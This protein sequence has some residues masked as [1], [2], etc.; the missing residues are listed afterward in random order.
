MMDKGYIYHDS[1]EDYYR[2]PFGAVASGNA[3]SLYLEVNDICQAFIELINFDGTTKTIP[4]KYDRHSYVDNYSVL[5]GVV[6]TNNS[7]G[8]LLYYFR[9]VRGG[10]TLYYGNNEECVG[11]VGKVYYDNPKPYQITVYKEF[12][13]PSWYKEGIIYQIFVDRFCNGNYNG[14][15]NNPKPNSFIYGNWNDEPLYI[16]DKEGRIIRWDFYGGNLSGVTNK[17]QY[18]KSLGV[19]IIY[20]NPIFESSSC[21]KYD[22]G[23]YEHIDSM[24]GTDE[25]FKELCEEAEALDMKIILDGVFSHTGADS[26]YF[27]KFGRYNTFGAC[28]S[29]CSPYYS[30]YRYYD[31][32]NSYECWWG[33]DNQPNVDELN[34]SYVDYIIR[35]EN[36]IIAK[37]LKFGASGWR[38][39]VAD[40]LP[41][42]FIKM[43][44]AK[45]NEVKEDN[46]LI[47]EV[48]EDASNKI[49]YSQRREYLLGDELDSVT[50][51]PVKE[52]IISLV[53]R[54]ISSDTFRKRLMSLYENYPKENFYSCM[55]VLGTH[56]TERIFT[57][58][59]NRR[60][61][62]KLAVCIQ[63]TLPGV[64]LIYYGDEAGLTGGKDPENRK[65]Y[66]WGREDTEILY[67]YKHLGNTRSSND[68][69][70]KGNFEMLKDTPE[71]IV[72]YRRGYEDNEVVVIV[73][74]S[75]T[76]MNLCLK[77]IRGRYK[78]LINKNVNSYYFENQ[79]LDITLSPY[80]CK[81]LMNVKL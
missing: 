12:N 77:N 62:L 19:N 53:K 14:K 72:V 47:G 74:V 44:K 80:E 65:S 71:S 48:W 46:V 41:D 29:R 9:I 73:N 45:M 68:A 54:E 32:P 81:I 75:D 66:P 21:H 67:W 24:L 25:E 61:L 30:W 76:P 27:N 51:Y 11:G 3:V 6:E 18:I 55:N 70:K 40:E 8:I 78:D 26:K 60:E 59:D 28:Q 49:S 38:L 39:D 63:M 22:V 10:N 37:W 69:L 17:L 50:N 15:I 36:S 43:I 58:L 2:Q 79:G 23:D 5:K 20:M 4:M 57:R 33:I 13:V 42:K 52:M 56:D 16:K 34:E 64:P 7:K 35:D 1:Q 31:Y